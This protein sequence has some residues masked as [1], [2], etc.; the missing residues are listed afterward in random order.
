MK[1]VTKSG[2]VPGGEGG[3]QERSQD[4]ELTTWNDIFIIHKKPSKA[5]D[6]TFDTLTGP[7]LSDSVIM[8]ISVFGGS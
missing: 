5:M 6:G 8:G 4:S 3:L 2:H 1:E 7:W